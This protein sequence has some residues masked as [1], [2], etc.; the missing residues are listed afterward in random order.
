MKR[1]L[2]NIATDI[3]YSKLGDKIITLTGAQKLIAKY[4]VQSSKRAL[5]AGA[6]KMYE[7]GL[8]VG[9]FDD[10]QQALKKHWVS[11]TEYANQYEFYNKTEE[12][13]EEYISR[14]KMAYFYWVYAPGSAKYVFCNKTRFL[15]A[16]KKYI[17]RKWLFAPDASFE[18]FKQM[19]SSVDCIVK[20]CDGKLGQGIFKTY[21]DDEHKDYQKLYET[22]VNN[23][24]L[25]EQCI[26]ECDELKAFHPRSL[27][28]LRVVTIANREKA[29]VFS[30]VF[31]TGVGESVVDNTHQ[32]GV[33][34]QINVVDGTVETDGANTSGE[35]F[36][37]HPDSGIAIKGFKIPQWDAIVETCCEAAKLTGNPITGWDVVVNS[38]REVEL[39]EANYGPDM[40]MMQTRYKKGAKKRIYSLIK[41][42][43]GI[44]MK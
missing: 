21:K 5:L 34:A 25:V 31:R 35:R 41:E 11:Y 43:R 9:T 2:K 3:A 18:D 36:S 42:Y 1:S 40:D 14:L 33:S 44:E 20:P 27:N 24:M 15:K 12:E 39:I 30:G 37:N 38:D 7:K 6:R 8:A 17:H 16:F 4:R 22:C 23:R 26:E 10:Y 28:T 29:C 32:G 19:V 13:R